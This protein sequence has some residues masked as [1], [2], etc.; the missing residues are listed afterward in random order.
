MKRIDAIAKHRPFGASNGHGLGRRAD[1]QFK[2]YGDKAERQRLTLQRDD[3]RRAV[4]NRTCH[5]LSSFNPV[6]AMTAL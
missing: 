4:E 1:S 6:F 2:G 3:L 5:A